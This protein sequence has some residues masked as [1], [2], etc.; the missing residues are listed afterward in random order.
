MLLLCSI[1]MMLITRMLLIVLTVIVSR[2]SNRLLMCGGRCVRLHTFMLSCWYLLTRR[3]G[4]SRR[5]LWVLCRASRVCS[6]SR[7]CGGWLL[8]R[9]MLLKVLIILIPIILICRLIIVR[10]STLLAIV[11]SRVIILA[12]RNLTMC[13][14][15][16]LV[17][18][19]VLYWITQLMI[20]IM[21]TFLL[22]LLLSG[23]DRLASRICFIGPSGK[24]HSIIGEHG[25]FRQNV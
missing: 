25:V 16:T 11:V 2:V 9:I 1:I 14:I 13:M 8:P 21:F 15:L 5:S 17:F 18:V 7:N 3:W 20:R 12:G 19:L 6:L 22:R 24:L 10:V 23:I 4:L